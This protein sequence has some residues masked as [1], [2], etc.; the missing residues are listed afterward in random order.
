MASPEFIELCPC[1]GAPFPD[2]PEVAEVRAQAWIAC[3]REF[4]HLP[5]DLLESTV[6]EL[7]DR[8]YRYDGD[9]VAFSVSPPTALYLSNFRDEPCPS[10]AEMNEERAPFRRVMGADPVFAERA[11]GALPER[12]AHIVRSRLAAVDEE[13]L[14]SESGL[15][16]GRLRQMELQAMRRISS[17]EDYVA[18]QHAALVPPPPPRFRIYLRSGLPRR[19][20]SSRRARRSVAVRGSPER[21]RPEDDDDLDPPA[22]GPVRAP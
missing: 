16:V 3:E 2:D 6:D 15:P 5:L 7:I 13:T 17:L 22:R 20:P 12:E 11:L 19:R 18:R 1:C 10:E 8:G 21:P 9:I 14:V 4:P